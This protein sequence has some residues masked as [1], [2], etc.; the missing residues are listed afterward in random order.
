MNRD[1]RA[2]L[3]IGKGLLFLLPIAILSS[4]T[5]VMASPD[6]RWSGSHGIGFEVEYVF[7]QGYRVGGWSI[8]MGSFDPF[9]DGPI[10]S[11]ETVFVD[12]D[13]FT[14]TT[15]YQG[16]EVTVNGR[17][18]AFGACVGEVLYGGQR[19]GWTVYGRM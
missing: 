2:A 17:F 14:F 10:V 5:I 9:A 16:G 12:G 18:I 8:D 1:G 15:V 6:V 4:C 3:G 11:D 13:S 19:R 7:P